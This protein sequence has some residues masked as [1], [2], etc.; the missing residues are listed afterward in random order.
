MTAPGDADK[1][2]RKALEAMWSG[3]NAASVKMGQVG[4]RRLWAAMMELFA[5]SM[6]GGAAEMVVCGWREVLFPTELGG[7]GVVTGEEG[8]DREQ[9]YK[10]MLAVVDGALR[11][12]ETELNT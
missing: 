5:P 8:R 9:V 2:D 10:D 6:K 11:M 3:A 1:T 4:Q 12:S 7:W